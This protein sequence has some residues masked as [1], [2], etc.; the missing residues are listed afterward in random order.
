METQC[1]ATYLD[2][3]M[4]GRREIVADFD[5]GDL[6][7]DGGA[8]LL[9]TTEQLTGVIRQ[10]AACFADHRKSD[11]IEHTV[12]ELVAQRVYALALGYEDLNDHDDLRRDP[13]LAA[14][15]GKTDPSGRTRQ[16]RRDR[17]KAL[18]GKSTLNRLELTPIGADQDSRYKKVACRTHDVERLFVTLFLQAYARPPERIALDLDATDDP[19]HGHQLGRFF[20]GYYKDYC[21]L[22]LD[23]FCGDHLLCA[24]LRPADIDASA[25]SVKQLQRIVEQIRRAWP[26][27]KI[28]I[29]A[30]S[31]FCRE[32]TMAWCEAKGVDYI[33]GLAQNPRLLA[34]IADELDQARQQFEATGQ[35]ARIF[36]EL[37]YRTLETWS[38]ERRVVA[39][40]EHLVKGANPRFVVTSLSA[41]DRSA[42]P[43]YEEDYC[44]RGE[45]ENRI[46]EQ[47][48]HLFAD[49]TSAGTMRA[50]QI[51]LF[52]SS[53]AY[54]L[55]NALRRLGLEG[56][57]MAEAQCQTIRL[58]LLKIGALVRVT[59]RKV[60]VHLASSCP[61]A[62]VFRRVHA[63]LSRIR[64]MVLR[65]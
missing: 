34:A 35:P 61:Y 2:F 51:R 30:D 21:Y 47:Q 65:C 13:L 3:P 15:V 54:T 11:R 36:A 48:L 64:L 19:I 9:R 44:A 60:W 26:E 12:E 24:R 18:A 28:T 27:V 37:R 1:N 16:R 10:F 8:L 50:N 17:G 42:R 20:H 6:T 32:P 46:K 58:K 23:I 52:F 25:G 33:F 45:A 59:V 53:I 7:S 38:R 39:K 63:R 29:R 40:A 56:T 5:G 62:E 55:L 57:E 14:V 4:L 22:P 41:E 31:G 43:L 49:R